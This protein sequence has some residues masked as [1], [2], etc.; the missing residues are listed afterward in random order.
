[1]NQPPVEVFDENCNKRRRFIAGAVCPRCA[2]MDRLIVSS[3]GESRCCVECGFSDN[4]PSNTLEQVPTRVTRA[5]ARRTETSAEVVRLL[6]SCG[7]SA[8]DESD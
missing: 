4:R 8:L 7:A 3:D 1:M 5:V 2:V 6:T